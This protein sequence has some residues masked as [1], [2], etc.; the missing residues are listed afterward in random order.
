M[1]TKTATHLAISQVWHRVGVA[2]IDL[3]RSGVIEMIGYGKGAVYELRTQHGC[4]AGCS[5][6]EG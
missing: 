6:A 4:R 1:R 3:R 2:L 5:C